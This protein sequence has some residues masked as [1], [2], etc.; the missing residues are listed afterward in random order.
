V[1][2]FKRK[3]LPAAEPPEADL[4]PI[5]RRAADSESSRVVQA[6]AEAQPPTAL[7]SVARL[8]WRAVVCV[9]CGGI[10][11]G[12]GPGP[13]RHGGYIIGGPTGRLDCLRRP[14]PVGGKP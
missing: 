1:S 14:W 2:R 11:K 8:D 3:V 9:D 10:M 7:L 5:I 4:P 6:G 13:H 12:S